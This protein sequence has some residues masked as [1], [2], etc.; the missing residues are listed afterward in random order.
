MEPYVKAA[1]TRAMQTNPALANYSMGTVTDTE[2]QMKDGQKKKNVKH[3]RLS[4]GSSHGAGG[5]G[6]AGGWGA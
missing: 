3:I 1:V 4:G 2:H 6:A 5:N